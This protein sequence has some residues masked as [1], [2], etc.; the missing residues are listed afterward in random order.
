MDKII[1]DHVKSDLI[2]S[3]GFFCWILAIV[4]KT[5]YEEYNK[6]NNNKELP[7]ESGETVLTSDDPPEYYLIVSQWDTL[8]VNI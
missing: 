3:V 5:M 6:N 7:D 2:A 1:P 4:V 8:S